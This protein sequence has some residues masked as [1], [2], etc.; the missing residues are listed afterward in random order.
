MLLLSCGNS[1]R[2]GASRARRCE[3]SASS[4]SYFFASSIASFDGY[5]TGTRLHRALKERQTRY[6]AIVMWD[7]GCVTSP[8]LFGLDSNGIEHRQGCLPRLTTRGIYAV[9]PHS[10]CPQTVR[11]V[12]LMGPSCLPHPVVL[13]RFFRLQSAEPHLKDSAAQFLLLLSAHPHSC[14]MTSLYLRKFRLL[15]SIIFYPISGKTQAVF[16]IS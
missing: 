6:L 7:Y 15:F 1:A 9:V 16:H 14:S 3:G 13:F 12:P 10:A 11:I 2:G 8:W 4:V 5:A